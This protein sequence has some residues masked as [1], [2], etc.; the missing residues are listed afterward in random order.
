[1]WNVR[2]PVLLSSFS[3]VISKRIFF[4][5]R[6]KIK[7]LIKPTRCIQLQMLFTKNELSLIISLFSSQLSEIIGLP[8]FMVY[9][10]AY[11]TNSRWRK[12]L[13]DSIVFNSLSLICYLWL[14][15][16]ESFD[17][18]NRLKSLL[19]QASRALAVVLC[20]CLQQLLQWMLA[21]LSGWGENSSILMHSI[22]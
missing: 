3:I 6:L 13:T 8:W 18:R 4:A 22:Y 21:L 15:S 1:M 16:M 17:G 20:A 10:N 7:S 19:L 11:S 5:E 14:S 2:R 12:S 9:L